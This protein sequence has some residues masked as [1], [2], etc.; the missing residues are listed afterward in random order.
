MCITTKSHM[1]DQIE[2]TS[3]EYKSTN[4][5]YRNVTSEWNIFEKKNIEK[6]MGNAQ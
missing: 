2:N 6:K 4:T 5:Y 3:M 1:C